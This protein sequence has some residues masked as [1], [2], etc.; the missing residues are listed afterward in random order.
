MSLIY[1]SSSTAA[2]SVSVMELAISNQRLSFR[3][4]CLLHCLARHRTPESVSRWQKR[5]VEEEAEAERQSKSEWPDDFSFNS[6]GCFYLVRFPKE[7]ITFYD[8]EVPVKS[9]SEAAVHSARLI[10]SQV[11]FLAS[12]CTQDVW[13]RKGSIGCAL[14][15]SILSF[16]RNTS[17]SNSWVKVNDPSEVDSAFCSK[18]TTLLC[19]FFPT[20]KSNS[21]NYNL[22]GAHHSC[23]SHFTETLHQKSDIVLS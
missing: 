11:E 4:T 6:L 13:E 23:R 15:L 5:E 8:T 10:A 1:H 17:W 2:L 21:R 7:R 20:G 19:F 16:H 3:G 18:I 9:A 12:I 14:L 22:P